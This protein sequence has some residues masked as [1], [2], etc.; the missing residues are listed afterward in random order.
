MAYQFIDTRREGPVE[1]LTL[2]RPEVRNAFN[3]RVVQEL[4]AWA[5]APE[6]V[7]AANALRKEVSGRRA[8]DTIGLTADTLAAR[9]ASVEGQEGL[10]AFLEKR[11]A[12]WNVSR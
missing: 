9:R 5:A 6:A 12:R 7:A 2:N 11:T 3:E 4:T 10:R 1:Y 8:P